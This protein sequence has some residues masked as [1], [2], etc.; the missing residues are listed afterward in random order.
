MAML[1]VCCILASVG[2]ATIACSPTGTTPSCS[3]CIS[4][5]GWSHSTAIDSDAPNMPAEGSAAATAGSMDARWC[6]CAMRQ[7]GA[8]EVLE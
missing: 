6:D 3:G 2:D 4:S 1:D 8:L 5:S 7:M